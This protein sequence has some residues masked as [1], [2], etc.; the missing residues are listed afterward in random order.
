MVSPAAG[1]S[2]ERY[3]TVMSG[4]PWLLEHHA[5]Q[6]DKNGT[7]LVSRQLGQWSVVVNG[8]EQTTPY[9]N[10]MWKD[11]FSKIA[12]GSARASPCILMLGVAAGGSLKSLYARFPGCSI[13][14]IEHDPEMVDLLGELKLYKPHP[15]PR[16]IQADAMEAASSLNEQFDLIIVDLF[17]GEEPPP[18]VAQPPFITTLGK[19]LAPKGQ[20]LVNT[21]KHVEYLEA[22]HSNFS[23]SRQWVF[24]Y[25]FLGLFSDP[26]L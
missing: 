3:T 26:K 19:L 14:A 4:I 11:A 10:A 17:V 21:F 7:I 23:A 13:T 6:S 12:M 22:Y 15:K 20:L 24:R 16:L 18:W 2:Q 25:N 5:R 1:A 9:T 8:C